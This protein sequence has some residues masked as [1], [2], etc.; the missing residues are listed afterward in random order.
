MKLYQVLIIVLILATLTGA[1]MAY[2]AIPAFTQ[3]IHLLLAT[4]LMGLE[5][6]IWLRIRKESHT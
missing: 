3:P 6:E 5:W 4:A 1:I 2:F